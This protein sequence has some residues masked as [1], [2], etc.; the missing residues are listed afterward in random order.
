LLSLAA[1]R[2]N[3]ELIPIR[4][5][6]RS[7]K[8]ELLFKVTRLAQVI[9]R[10]ILRR[11]YLIKRDF[12]YSE[13]IRDYNIQVIHCPYQDLLI[14]GDTPSITTVHDV[15]ELHFPEF[16]SSA[17]RATRAVKYKFCIDNSSAVIVSYEHVKKDILRYFNKPSDQVFVCLNKMDSL[18]FEP[19]LSLGKTWNREAAVSA[20]YILYPAATWKHKNHLKLIEALKMVH[21]R[22]QHLRLIC[23]GH[24]TDFFP[25]IKSEIE[26]LGMSEYIEFRGIV[27]EEELFGLYV[28]ALAVVVP[29]LYEAGSYPLME[30]MFIGVPVIC[31][32]VTSL[33]DTI[34]DR[35]FVFNP[36]DGN[37]IAEKIVSICYDPAFW[38]RNLECA[39]SSLRRLTE[40]GIQERVDV[41]YTSLLAK[42]K[43]P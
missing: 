10:Y 19:F 38:T 43:M 2:S 14:V 22:G 32:S 15:Q 27:N 4:R 33:P 3:I 5:F 40:T 35:D 16:F 24:I 42:D 29:T 8:N 30:S 28:N 25:T 37:E 11:S 20:N 7:L 31:S 1:Q 34:G 6:K 18:W 26:E 36:L 13:I 17:E 12:L 41:V 39:K 9:S 21:R 23:T